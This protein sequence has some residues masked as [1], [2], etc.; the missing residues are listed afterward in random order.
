MGKAAA[1]TTVLVLTGT[2]F[3]HPAHAAPAAKCA[4][5]TWRLTKAD[6]TVTQSSTRLRITGGAGATLTL[7]GGKAVHRYAGSARLTETGT[8]GGA[9]VTG[10]L[11]YRGVL[12]M[13]AKLSGNRLIG[14]V[15]SASGNAT[16]KLRQTAPLSLDPAP[17][18]LVALLKAR[19]FTG[20]P[21]NAKI[22]C[23]RGTLKLRQT[24]SGK[25]GTLKGVWTYR[26]A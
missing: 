3:A 4:A 18:D 21:Y 16:L 26:R 2:V 14:T 1:L 24:D 13:K 11:R 25:S 23:S 19:E 12:R 8:S 9:K 7:S 6:L 10:W 15:S 5:G 17:R 22:T 20:V